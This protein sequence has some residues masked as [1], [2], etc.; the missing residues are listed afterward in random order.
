MTAEFGKLMKNP[1]VEDG[2]ETS[3]GDLDAKN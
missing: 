1:N 3:I 2:A